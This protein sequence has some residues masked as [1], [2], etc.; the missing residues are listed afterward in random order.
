MPDKRP[1]D[2]TEGLGE[3]IRAYRA[4]TGLSPRSMA[5]KIGMGEKSLSDIEY[6]RRA[7]PPG[8]IDSILHVLAVFERDVEKAIDV[9]KSSQ[10]TENEPFEMPVDGDPR[11]EWQRAVIGRAA[12]DSGLI[13]PILVGDRHPRRS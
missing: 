3:L 1:P 12:V 2:Y 10:A 11:L 7:C 13:L 5:L 8:L 4:Y 9:A 6:G